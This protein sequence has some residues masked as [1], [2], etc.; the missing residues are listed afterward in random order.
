MADKVAKNQAEIDAAIAAR[1]RAE[2]ALAAAETAKVTFAEQNKSQ[3]LSGISNLT[4]GITDFTK[5]LKSGAT[6][7]DFKS[8]TAAAK[9]A[10][11]A[12]QQVTGQL[13]PQL[14]TINQNITSVKSTIK[15]GI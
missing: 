12:S 15:G 1:A 6:G 11:E 2:R 9:A 10:I 3:I 5:S 8:S 4:K 14:A 7:S 13:N